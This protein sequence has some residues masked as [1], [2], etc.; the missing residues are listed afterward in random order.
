LDVNALPVTNVRKVFTEGRL[1][2][3]LNRKKPKQE[4]KHRLDGYAETR[5]IAMA[6]S[7]ALIDKNSGQALWQ[8]RRTSSS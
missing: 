7:P 2:K 1:N 8:G 6:C 5:L 4:Y 3:A